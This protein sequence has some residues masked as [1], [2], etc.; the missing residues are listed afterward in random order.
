MSAGRN[1][2]AKALANSLGGGVIKINL[3]LLN[4]ALARGAVSWLDSVG[5]AVQAILPLL[6]ASVGSCNL[7]HLGRSMVSV[8]L[9]DWV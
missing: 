2:T 6:A 3:E 9:Q 8:T 1:R 4:I 7:G 5:W